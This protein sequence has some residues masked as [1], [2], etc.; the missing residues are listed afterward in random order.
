DFLTARWGLYTRRLGRMLY[1][2]I[3]HE[4]W[5]LHDAALVELDD[6]LVS[7]A[8]LPFLAGR[9]PDSVLWSPG[10]TTDFGLPRRRRPVAA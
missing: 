7:A 6:T 8:G 4:V 10:V 5:P 3:H 1:V 2:P 9:E